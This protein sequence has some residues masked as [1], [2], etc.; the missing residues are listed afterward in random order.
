MHRTI[1]MFALRVYC[2]TLINLNDFTNSR[3]LLNVLFTIELAVSIV[4]ASSFVLAL[5]VK[6]HL[7]R[8]SLHDDIDKKKFRRMSNECLEN[9]WKLELQGMQTVIQDSNDRNRS[10]LSLSTNNSDKIISDVES[11]VVQH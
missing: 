9:L 11:I 6:K 4:I 2:T 10:S 3:T 5:I 7:H 8:D 1:I